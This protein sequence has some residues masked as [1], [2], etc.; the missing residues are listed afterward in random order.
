MRSTRF[1]RI[2]AANIGPNRFHH[3]LAVSW[4]MSIPRSAS[5][6]STF[7][8]DRGYFTYSRVGGERRAAFPRLVSHR[9][10][11]NRTC[12]FRSASGSP[13]D[14]VKAGLPPLIEFALNAEY[15]SLV[16]LVIRVHRSFL[17]RTSLSSSCF[18]SPCARLSRA[19]TTTEA[20]P[21]VSSVS[22]RRGEPSS[23]LGRRAEFPCSDLQ[24]SCR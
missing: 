9:L 16:G 20:P 2:S 6:S 17:R 10:S 13:E 21:S 3:S 22:G 24:P 5:R 4:Q 19:P 14:I 18:P 12:V 15:P 11:P 8:N 7:R 23:V 1:L